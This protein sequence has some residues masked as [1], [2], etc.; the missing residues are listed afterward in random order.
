GCD[1]LLCASY[2]DLHVYDLYC[3]AGSTLS[4]L[5]CTNEIP[6]SLPESHSIKGKQVYSWSPG[7]I[8]EADINDDGKTE[9]IMTSRATSGLALDDMI[10]LSDQGKIIFKNR[11]MEDR[12]NRNDMIYRAM[13]VTT[14]NYYGIKEKIIIGV[15]G[16]VLIIADSH[17]RLAAKAVAPIAFTDIAVIKKENSTRI[18]LPVN[19][20]DSIVML[21][22]QNGWEHE[23]E[24]LSFKGETAQIR[25]NIRGISD[26]LALQM[27]NCS[28]SGKSVS[29]EPYIIET[30]AV[31]IRREKLPHL[32]HYINYN[33]WI[34][35]QFSY[36]NIR[37]A[38]VLWL[39]E[40]GM[41]VSPSGRAWTLDNRMDY[42][43]T[44]REILD[45]AGRLEKEQVPFLIQNS[46]GCGGFLSLETIEKILVTAPEYFIGL[47]GSE[48]NH[49]SEL[50][51]FMREYLV[52]E[53]D[54]LK[55]YGNR[56]LILRE[57]SQFWPIVMTNP[58][59]YQQIF[60]QGTYR[61]TLIPL[62]EEAASR[63]GEIHI[64]CRSGLWLC[65]LVKQWGTRVIADQLR[66]N[67]LYVW[68]S[69]MCGHHHLRLLVAHASLGASFFM[70]HNGSDNA[71]G[72]P[73]YTPGSGSFQWT[74]VGKDS[75]IPFIHLLGQRKII[76]PKR[77]DCAH[78]SSAAISLRPLSSRIRFDLCK[79][80]NYNQFVPARAHERYVF[81]RVESWWAMACTFSAD[82]AY[83]L[84]GKRRHYM[85]L[86][87]HNAHGFVPIVSNLFTREKLQKFTII[88]ETDGDMWY[89][90]KKTC[91]PQQG[92]EIILDKI[93]Q[94][95]NKLPFSVEGDVFFQAIVNPKGYRL[96]LVDP[97]IIEP[98]EHQVNIGLK[99]LKI[100]S[101]FDIIKN[102]RIE[103]VSHK[104]SVTVPAGLFRII[105]INI[106]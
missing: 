54:L 13:S 24:N 52:P 14:G 6:Y 19:F 23:F 42:Q 37:F 2:I 74:D 10:I 102:E 98:K 28:S 100:I 70:F 97:D 99:K 66:V 51:D 41:E 60:G 34:R 79:G 32:E 22:M 27:K 92:K 75:L 105:E 12:L 88:F 101:I 7:A 29:T 78:I 82:A 96:I 8:T 95:K 90:G 49:F 9:I 72:E 53:M 58:A 56:K 64:A 31:F 40:K 18:I 93:K 62:A 104:I 26:N 36:D 39:S 5:W 57:G 43:L 87:P 65:D 47:I 11:F 94:L 16:P 71:S 46:H 15:S 4:P 63:N 50:A 35:R 67:P 21:D 45:I 84:W 33:K 30:A 103:A 44:G 17:C 73:N 20:D 77:V 1:W 59:L 86:I 85:N 89:I 25:K 61:E 80:H 3:L 38:V 81:S 83:Y 106:L 91:S 68:D 76:P 48:T 69:V 55:K